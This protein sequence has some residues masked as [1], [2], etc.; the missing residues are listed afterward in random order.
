MLTGSIVQ[1]KYMGGKLLGFS[2]CCYKVTQTVSIWMDAISRRIND[3]NVSRK[4]LTILLTA[5]MTFAIYAAANSGTAQASP[6]EYPVLLKIND[7]FVAYTAPKPPYLDLHYRMMIP[8]RSISK[9]IGAKVGYDGKNKTATIS[10]DDKKVIFTIGSKT[11]TVN[12]T[13]DQMDTIP[14]LDQNSMFIPISVLAN[15]LGIQN[16]WDQANHLY[17]LTGD[18]LMQTD[19][20]KYALEDLEGGAKIAPP[21][22]IISN[23]AFRLVSY[24]YD[25]TKG[26][27]TVKAKNITGTDIPEGAEDVAPYI[28]TD[29]VQFLNPNRERPA[30]EKDGVL[31]VSIKSVG[32]NQ[33]GSLSSVEY[34]LVKGRMLDRSAS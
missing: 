13:A 6:K 15:H 19:I 32:L 1:S 25:T 16:S 17:T 33:N 5:V 10:M 9:L 18:N 2:E 8:L 7:Y 24:T 34:L 27:F 22:K 3:M 14:V 21:G 29:G 12:G 31:E 28:L 20:I 4:M 30:V 23:D 26:N 11:V